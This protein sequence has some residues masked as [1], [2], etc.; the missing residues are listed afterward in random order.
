[1]H[2]RIHIFGAKCPKNGEKSGFSP[3]FSSLTDEVGEFEPEEDPAEGRG[4]SKT[5][6][7]DTPGMSTK[8]IFMEEVSTKQSKDREYFGSLL[9][10]SLI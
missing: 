8:Q 4:K 3:G 7:W 5:L 6:V 9:S 10:E 1:M 2:G